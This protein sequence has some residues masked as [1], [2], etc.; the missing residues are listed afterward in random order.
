MACGGLEM[1]CKCLQVMTCPHNV[2]LVTFRPHMLRPGV[3]DEPTMQTISHPGDMWPQRLSQ[4]STCMGTSLWASRHLLPWCVGSLQ[5]HVSLSPS[6]FSDWRMQPLFQYSVFL[7]QT[8][9]SSAAGSCRCPTST[10]PLCIPTLGSSEDPSI[11]V[12]CSDV[13]EMRGCLP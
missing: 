10:S 9:R 8:P 1:C 13:V 12:R 5:T 7:A 11:R 2:G 3:G 6:T 4:Q